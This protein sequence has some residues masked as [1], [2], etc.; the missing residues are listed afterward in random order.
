[1]KSNFLLTSLL[2]AAATPAVADSV[3]DMCVDRGKT[4]ANCQCAAERL[5]AEI[6]D[7][8][9]RIYAL[10]GKLYRENSAGGMGMSE[11]WD[12][13]VGKTAA[14]IGKGN[15]AVLGITNPAGRAHNRAIKDC[16]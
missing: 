9:Y 4:E 14:E 1:M 5:K 3:V 16:R 8:D 10:V 13:A 11:A 12:A 6:A 2:F 15:T 7:E